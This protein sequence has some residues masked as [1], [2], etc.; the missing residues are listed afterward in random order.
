ME[1]L[2]FHT[3]QELRA[4][5]DVVLVTIIAGKGSAPRGAGARMLVC[6][7]GSY[8]GTIGGGKVEFNAIKR[9]K[10]ILKIKKSVI[11]NYH[12]TSTQSEQIGMVCGGS[13]VVFFQY[14]S[15]E[16]IEFQRCC[17]QIIDLYQ[18]DENTWLLMEIAED[19]DWN[20]GIYSMDLGMVG[21]N[22]P[23]LASML[24][25]KSVIKPIGDKEYYVEPLIR[26]GKVYIFGG[27]HVAQELVPVLSH[28]DFKCVVLDD[29]KEF[30]NKIIFPTAEEVYV[31][32]FSSIHDYVTITSNDYAIIMTREH[33]FDYIIQAQILRDKP[34]YI[35]IM[36]SSHKI[37]YITEKLL[38]D[39]FAQKEIDVCHMPIGTPIQAETPAE[40]AI[41]IAGELIWNRGMRKISDQ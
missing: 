28:L 14:I 27:G 18:K 5:H 20:M 40:I 1:K 12:L 19:G 31:C 4:G 8:H 32:E 7:D 37:K 36:G 29:R 9:A 15:N 34:Y 3:L 10:E 38:Q 6:L 33:K 11:E 35:G 13:L 26:A 41:S 21:I 30:A 22:V 25:P 24:L 16:N 17:Q 39:G 2:F 23:Q